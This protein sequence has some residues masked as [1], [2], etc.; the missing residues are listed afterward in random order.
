MASESLPD[1]RVPPMAGVS[2]EMLSDERELV[3]L[4]LRRD[5]KA[6]ARFVAAYADGVYAYVRHRL[7]PRG[8]VVEDVVQE[9]FLAAF[10]GLSRFSGPSLKAWLHG[11]ARHK[12]EDFYRRSLREPMPLVDD[13]DENVVADSRPLVDETIDRKRMVERTRDVLKRLPEPNSVA[14]LWRYWENRSAREMAE[15]TGKTE[16]A[17]ERLLAR[18]RERF[19]QL[20]DEVQS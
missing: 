19:R 8:D 6:T 17:I 11:I 3:A 2:A 13:E 9:I 16:K 7:A 18:A 10:S 5:R 14:L 4:I 20:W 12:V 15:A 1:R